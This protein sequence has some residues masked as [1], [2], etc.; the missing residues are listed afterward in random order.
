MPSTL[1]LDFFSNMKS[2]LK[3]AFEIRSQRGV[4]DPIS[5]KITLSVLID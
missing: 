4:W 1:V 5:K 2:D 3:P